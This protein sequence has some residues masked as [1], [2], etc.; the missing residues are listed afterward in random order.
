MV[1]KGL[2]AH[3]THNLQLLLWV[4]EKRTLTKCIFL[5]SRET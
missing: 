2:A 4:I 5:S 1:L 3:E